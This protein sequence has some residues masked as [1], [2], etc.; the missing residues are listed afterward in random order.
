MREMR[1]YKAVIIFF[2][3]F[4]IQTTVLSNVL[5]L[6]ISPNI[7]LCLTVVFTYLYDQNFGLVCGLIFTLLIDFTTSMVVGVETFTVALACIPVVIVRM[8]FNPERTVPCALLAV[9]ATFINIFGVWALY[10]ISGVSANISSSLSMLPGSLFCN[11][12][13]TIVLHLF[14]VRTIIRHKKDRN[15]SGGVM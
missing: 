15:Y 11:V 13:L 2:I 4:I 9:A 1:Y 8:I 5:V 14:F 3:A 12:I 6:G 7:L 10:N